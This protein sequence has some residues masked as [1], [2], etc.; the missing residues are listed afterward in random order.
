MRGG[1]ET[2]E[3]GAY[4]VRGDI[5][6]AVSDAITPNGKGGRWLVGMSNVCEPFITGLFKPN[7]SGLDKRVSS[8][9]SDGSGK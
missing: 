5:Q 2:G 3:N 1:I 7:G 8:I 9:M 4:R 6:R